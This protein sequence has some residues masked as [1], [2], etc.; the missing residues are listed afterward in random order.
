MLTIITLIIGN[1]VLTLAIVIGLICM[2]SRLA[3]W[4]NKHYGVTI[5]RLTTTPHHN[6]SDDTGDAREQ[7]NE[8]I[9]PANPIQEVHQ[10][11][12]T[13]KQFDVVGINPMYRTGKK[14][15][16]KCNAKCH[17]ATIKSLSHFHTLILDICRTAVNQSGKEP[18][19]SFCSIMVERNFLYIFRKENKAML[20]GALPSLLKLI[21]VAVSVSLITTPIIVHLIKRMTLTIRPVYHSDNSKRE[22]Y[23][24]NHVHDIRSDG[25]NSEKMYGNPIPNL[26]DKYRY[27]GRYNRPESSMF[28]QRNTTSPNKLSEGFHR[29]ILFYRSYYSGKEPLLSLGAWPPSIVAKSAHSVN[30]HGPGIPGPC[31]SCDQTGIIY[32]V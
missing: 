14:Q 13:S 12:E 4:L 22:V 21:V 27:E 25:I 29:L 30:R 16:E 15:K 10:P 8:G 6:T 26:G 19:L 5:R 28:K 24:P 23:P 11:S 3:D 18:F 9:Y 7:T 1:L 2:V 32:R 20:T 31:L 17:N